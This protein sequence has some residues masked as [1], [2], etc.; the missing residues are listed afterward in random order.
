MQASRVP[1]KGQPRTSR[2]TEAT[3]EDLCH[4][5]GENRPVSRALSPTTEHEFD[6]YEPQEVHKQREGREI[7]RREGILM[8]SARCG[9][10]L[11]MKFQVRTST[12]R[13]KM[14]KLYIN[15][16]DDR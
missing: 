14:T 7:V 6:G 4:E 9:A 12:S 11:S 16:R 3:C 5:K 13:I 1:T 2:A 10:T 8:S 15:F